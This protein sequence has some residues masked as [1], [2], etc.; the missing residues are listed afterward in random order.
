MD[1][2]VEPGAN[3]TFYD[4]HDNEVV[5]IGKIGED[6]QETPEMGAAEVVDEEEGGTSP[7]CEIPLDEVLGNAI[8]VK[9]TSDGRKVALSKVKKFIDSEFVPFLEQ[10][11]D[12]VAV[13]QLVKR[14]KL[15]AQGQRD[16]KAFCRQMSQK[17]W[18]GDNVLKPTED[19]MRYYQGV[20]DY[21]LEEWER[22][23]DRGKGKTS[24]K[25]VDRLK[26]LYR[27]MDEVCGERGDVFFS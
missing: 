10:G 25:G 8:F 22:V 1:V 21:M 14:K 5:N 20:D 9:E 24:Q 11:Y 23:I 2:H 7:T 26:M 16:Y 12:W 15:L 17:E 4:I 3:A 27:R 19:G 18:Y 13:W 6:A